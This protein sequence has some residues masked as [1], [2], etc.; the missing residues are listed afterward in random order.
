MKTK[1]IKS[2]TMSILLAIVLLLG[3]MPMSVFAADNSTALVITG[4]DE[5][6]DYIYED[7]VLEIKNGG[8]YEIKNADPAAATSDIIKVSAPSGTVNITLS[9]VN[10]VTTEGMSVPAFEIAGDCTTDITL[11]DGTKNILN[12]W[13]SRGNNYRNYAGLQNGE[14]HLSI[15]CEHFEEAGHICDSDCGSLEAVG[16]NYAA[17]IGGSSGMSGKNIT[18]HGGN[19]TADFSGNSKGYAGIGG[20]NASGENITITGG[21]II[22]SGQAGIGGGHNGDGI[23]ITISG[24]MVNAT[25][26]NGAGIGG[27][28]DGD[29]SNITISGGVVTA[30]SRN[31]AGIGG[32]HNGDGSNITISGGVVTATSTYGAGV[33]AG[34]GGDGSNITISGGTVTATSTD[35]GAG[36]G[37]GNKGGNCGTITI[38]GGVVTATSTYGAGIGGGESG[39]D[40]SNITISGGTV[41]ATSEEGAGIGGGE[42]GGDGSN[43]TI[44]GGVVT[45]TSTNGAGI[46]VG[47]KG[48]I[49]EKIKIAPAANTEIYAY[50]GANNTGTPVNGSPFASVT[51]IT[52]LLS[53]NAFYS[54]A[55]KHVHN[56]TYTANENVITETCYCGH[57]QTATVTAPQDLIYNGSAKEAFVVYSDNWKGGELNVTYSDGGIFNAGDVM[58]TITK[59]NSTATV[60]YTIQKAT[61][62]ITVND[63]TAKQYEELPQFTYIGTGLITGDDMI[64]DPTFSTM[65]DMTEAGTFEVTASG[66]DAGSNYTITYVPGTLIV[67]AH[68]EHSGGIATCTE[69]AICNI[70]AQPYGELEAHSY[71][72]EW[73]IDDN[74]HWHECTC[75]AKSDEV[76]HSGGTA[77]CKDKA[78]C[79]ACD[80]AY[81]ELE[82]HTYEKGKCSVCEVADQNYVPEKDIPKT[83]D[84]GQMALWMAF[85]F[86][87]GGIIIDVAVVDRK[88]RNTVK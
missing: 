74:N 20:S 34:S 50:N 12:S 72:T 10:I 5:G 30:T 75:G 73:K 64:T 76:A 62:T 82:A 16:G 56:Y 67:E 32:G 77:T 11:A 66:A 38:S 35:G 14:K 59:G 1:N 13:E 27:S 24:G 47:S 28:S 69:K 63:V 9:G 78:I 81:G 17:C 29:G 39:G 23:N 8:T 36:V 52:D 15:S 58:A 71:G 26:A 2:K 65:A 43:I 83:S 68:T 55:E 49:A 60:N 46:G 84:N 41:T 80:A 48:G 7:G 51:D 70:C 18:I 31:G 40:G 61:V 44:S 25:G 54:Y 42:S 53:G 4:G 19:I 85:I 6:T 87:S 37:G 79:V 22:A 33:G 86:I 21:N 57:C 3:T 45:A 88:R